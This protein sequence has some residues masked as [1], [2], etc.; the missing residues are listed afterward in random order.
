MKPAT[1]LIALW[2]AAMGVAR[3][4]ITPVEL[5]AA[6]A[7]LES[8]VIEWRRDFHSHPELANREFRTSARVAEHLRGLGLEVRTGMAH[9]GVVATL[10]GG[11]P[12]PTTKRTLG[13]VSV[14]KASAATP[15]TPLVR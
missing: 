14:P 6:A 2:L 7:S 11:L 1:C 3:A 5:N 15:A 12:G 10:R 9:T 4:E 8:R 13:M